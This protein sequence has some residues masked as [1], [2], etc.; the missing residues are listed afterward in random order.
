MTD[1]L[2]KLRYVQQ[3]KLDV[4][5]KDVCVLTRIYLACPITR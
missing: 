4:L 1:V 5:F 2:S 3:N